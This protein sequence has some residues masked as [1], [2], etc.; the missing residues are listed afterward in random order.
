MESDP[1]NLNFRLGHT[2][3]S[4]TLINLW[5]Q[6][7][8]TDQAVDL[9]SKMR[10]TYRSMSEADPSLAGLRIEY[11][12]SL[13]TYVIVMMFVG[14]KAEAQVAIAEGLGILHSLD[15]AGALSGNSFAKSL[16]IFMECKRAGLAGDVPATDHWAGQLAVAPGTGWLGPFHAACALGWAEKAIR[17]GRPFDQLTPAERAKIDEF[18]ERAV[19]WLRDSSRLGLRNIDVYLRMPDL[20]PFR[21]LPKFRTLIGDLELHAQGR[22]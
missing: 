21:A 14:R 20:E 19:G 4:V 1:R 12:N 7:G 5:L 15:R 8:K 11:A 2:R 6:I 17:N 13:H 16:I 3:A 22:Q 10:D 9:V 18:G